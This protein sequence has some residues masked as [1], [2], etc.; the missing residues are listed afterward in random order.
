MGS[1]VVGCR[2]R[3]QKL[4]EATSPELM[5]CRGRIPGR[6]AP[7]AASEAPVLATAGAGPGAGLPEAAGSGAHPREE[8]WKSWVQAGGRSW[9]KPRC[10]YASEAC[11]CVCVSW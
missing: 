10:L 8:R 9:E 11:V 1:K 5:G 7:G 2:E 6:R 4:P 3:Q